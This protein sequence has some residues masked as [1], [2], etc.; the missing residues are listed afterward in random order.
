MAPAIEV[1]QS[2]AGIRWILQSE[3]RHS[4]RLSRVINHV[5]QPT[6]IT[7]RKAWH[8]I[9]SVADETETTKSAT[10][11]VEYADDTD[12]HEQRRQRLKEIKEDL[13]LRFSDPLRETRAF[14]TRRSQLRFIKKAMAETTTATSIV[15]VMFLP[16]NADRRSRRRRKSGG[17]CSKR[18]RALKAKKAIQR[19]DGISF[20]SILPTR[21]KSGPRGDHPDR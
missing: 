7:N 9:T 1:R 19:S 20:P 12:T 11:L 4:A 10:V 8:Q 13:A 14:H 18:L 6:S 3:A 17:E 2:T 15:S 21:P 5:P 16:P